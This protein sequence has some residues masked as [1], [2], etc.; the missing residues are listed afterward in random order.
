MRVLVHGDADRHGFVRIVAQIRA[1]KPHKAVDG[2]RGGGKEQQRQGDLAGHK[3]IM[4]AFAARTGGG[5]P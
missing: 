2:G 5:A 4:R 3:N 1:D